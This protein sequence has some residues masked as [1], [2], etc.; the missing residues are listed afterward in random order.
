M[1]SSLRSS[2]MDDAQPSIRSPAYKNSPYLKYLNLK[3]PCT[4]WVRGSK[5]APTLFSQKRLIEAFKISKI[6]A[7]SVLGT[8]FPVPPDPMTFHCPYVSPNQKFEE[9]KLN[10]LNCFFEKLKQLIG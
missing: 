1:R 9:T 4:E 7:A 2:S 5:H 8:G 10:F 6:E 3:H